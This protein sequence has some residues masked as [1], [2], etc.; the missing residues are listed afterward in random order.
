MIPYVILFTVIIVGF[1]ASKVNQSDVEHL[2]NKIVQLEKENQLLITEDLQLSEWIAGIKDNWDDGC[3]GL[4]TNNSHGELDTL[5]YD[6]LLPSHIADVREFNDSN[7]IVL[8]ITIE[9]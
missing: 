9:P 7:K 2:N 8:R 4:Y 3:L 5:T 6:T 1:L